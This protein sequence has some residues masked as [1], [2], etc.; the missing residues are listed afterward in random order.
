MKGFL[1]VFPGLQMTEQMTELLGLVKVEKVSMNR[2]KSAIRI[3]IVSPRLI[4]KK[5]IID[6]ER[7]IC[8]QLFPG[9]RIEI[10]IFE[11]YQLSGQYTP[12]KL[13]KAYRDSLLIE[14]KH[15]SKIGR[16]HV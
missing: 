7:G 13:L 11:K 2:D 4:H 3:A 15:Y 9:K 6:L 14:L 10:K 8:D 12:E 5:N 1:E 16:A